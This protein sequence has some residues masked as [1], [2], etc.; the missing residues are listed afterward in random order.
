MKNTPVVPPLVVRPNQLKDVVGF[1]RVTAWRLEEQG[2]FPKRRKIT[3]GGSVGYLYSEILEY[4]NNCEQI[5]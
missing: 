1:G 5:A 3:P 4:L 2:L